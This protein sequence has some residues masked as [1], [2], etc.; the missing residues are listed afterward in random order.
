MLR[1][2]GNPGDADTRIENRVGDPAANPYL[3][4]ASQVLSGLDGVERNLTPPDADRGPL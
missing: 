4:V 1:L 3:Y 2:V